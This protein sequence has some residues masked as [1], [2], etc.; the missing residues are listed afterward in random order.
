MEIPSY[1]VDDCDWAKF[2]KQKMR[3]A[4][5]QYHLPSGFINTILPRKKCFI[6]FIMPKVFIFHISDLAIIVYN[7][8]RV[9][10]GKD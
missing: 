4:L 6:L 1:T 9:C 10:L 7:S 2:Y 8:A 5:R 3:L